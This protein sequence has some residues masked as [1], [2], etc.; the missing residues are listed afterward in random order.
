M[1]RAIQ[2]AEKGWGKTRP[3]PLVGAVIVKENNILAEGYH[4]FYGGNHAEIDALK[5]INFNAEGTTLYVNLEPCSHYGK[6]PPCVDAIIKSKVKKVVIAL[7][8]PNSMVAGKGI[9]I[10]M[11]NGIEVI[12][13][14]LREEAAKLNEIFIKYI[15][16]KTP[17]C[18]LKTAMTIDGKIAT[19]KG[20]SKWITGEASRAYVHH[21]RNRVSGI[22]VGIGT[23]EQDNPRLN[24]RIPGKEVNQPIRI[25]A[26]SQCKLSPASYVIETAKQQPTIIAATGKASKEKMERLEAL[27]AKILI[28]PEEEGR[29]N[30]KALMVQLGKMEIDSILL[31]G[32]GTLNYAALEEG[33]VDKV[34]WFIA[35]KIIGGNKAITPVEGR[36]KGLIKDSFMIKD[37]SISRFDE[38]ILLEGYIREE[39]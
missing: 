26:D 16:T 8:D 12:T 24:T 19:V 18:I 23:V 27:G 33:I 32:G 11:K 10:L 6:T 15:T 35:P 39:R 1:K 5:K 37:T 20:D 4:Q 36:G 38:D 34:M 29:V 13:G 17:F 31:E 9:Q 22:M 14:V 7:E 3:N 28:L 21:I 25:I 2:L 30:L